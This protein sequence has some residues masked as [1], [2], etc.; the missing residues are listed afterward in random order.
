MQ[1]LLHHGQHFCSTIA[2]ACF[3]IFLSFCKCFFCADSEKST[4][5]SLALPTWHILISVNIF[6]HR[7]LYALQVTFNQHSTF[8]HSYENDCGPLIEAVLT[9]YITRSLMLRWRCLCWKTKAT[10]GIKHHYK[11]VIKFTSFL[12]FWPISIQNNLR[13]TRFLTLPVLQNMFRGL[14][15]KNLIYFYRGWQ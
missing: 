13:A 9:F 8:Q 6:V 1:V 7:L 5:F 3:Q 12:T 15:Y 2:L 14:H 11:S 4:Y 10:Y